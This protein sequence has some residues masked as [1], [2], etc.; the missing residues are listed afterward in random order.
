MAVEPSQQWASTTIQD[1]L[2]GRRPGGSA[3]EKARELRNV[4][5]IRTRVARLLGVRTDERAWRKGAF[6][7][8]ATARW[9][10]RLPEGWH[11]FNDIPV[12]ER[13]A[14]IDHVIVGPAGVFTVN[15]KNLTG[16]VWIAS[17]TFLHNGRKTSYLPKAVSEAKRAS[18]LL[19]AALGHRVD[20]R[21]VL[22]V[23]ADDW[24][25]KE[26]PSD[27]LV[28][29]PR[30]VKDWLLSQPAVLTPGDVITIS[31]AVSKPATWAVPR[32]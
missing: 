23:L 18:R 11:L 7:E 10:G 20:V 4:A 14:N 25:I 9:L 16:A 22:A 12:G 21:P 8:R 1:S 30:F 29:A 24:T 3:A 26:K 2:A 32:S 6:G 19:S 31:A 13:G 17:R 27:V 15:A 28:E 5:P